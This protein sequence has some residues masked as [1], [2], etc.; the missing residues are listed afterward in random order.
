MRSVPQGM[1][2]VQV[3]GVC[4]RLGCVGGW[5]LI[6]ISQLG[7]VVDGQIKQGTVGYCTIERISFL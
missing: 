5:G 2:G 6:R 1:M 3:V 4:R 7:E